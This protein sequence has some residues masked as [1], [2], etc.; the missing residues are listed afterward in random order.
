MLCQP[1][2]C[3]DQIAGAQGAT[4][5]PGDL[6]ALPSRDPKQ[7]LR[8][9]LQKF[10]VLFGSPYVQQ[11]CEAYLQLILEPAIYRSPRTPNFSWWIW[12]WQA[13]I[14]A[15]PAT[16]DLWNSTMLPGGDIEAFFGSDN[17]QDE[18]PRNLRAPLSF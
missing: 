17:L 3:L 4:C 1:K 16:P 5:G 6:C 14:L 8:G 10:R 13:S 7:I 15:D 9:G 12:I 2:A 18:M 11:N